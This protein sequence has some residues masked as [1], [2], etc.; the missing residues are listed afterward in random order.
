MADITTVLHETITGVKIVKAFGMEEYENKKF[1]VQTQKF[2]KLYLKITRIRNTASPA[3]EFLSVVVGGAMVYFGGQLVLI[4][5]VL[6]QANFWISSCD[7]P[8]DA[9]DKGVKHRE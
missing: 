2:F 7:I 6:M 1:N 3:T 4:D 8:N 9:F 5:K